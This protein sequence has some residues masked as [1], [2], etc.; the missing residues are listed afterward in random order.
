MNPSEQRLWNQFAE[1]I[2]GRFAAAVLA[3][4]AAAQAESVVAVRASET[5][6]EWDRLS[7]SRQWRLIATVLLVAVGTH[8]GLLWLQGPSGWWWWAIPGMAGV[9][10]VT[11]LALASMAE[12]PGVID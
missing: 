3:A 8:L 1:S 2:V 5:R 12:R 9:F 4:V 6:R 7:A 10:A 11:I